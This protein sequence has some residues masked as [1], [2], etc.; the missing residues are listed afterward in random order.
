ME[1]NIIHYENLQLTQMRNLNE[2]GV[3]SNQNEDAKNDSDV[4]VLN[5]YKKKK[6]DKYDEL[7]TTQDNAKHLNHVLPP[8]SQTSSASSFNNDH[9]SST[10]HG[11]SAVNPHSQTLI[12]HA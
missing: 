10:F 12:H 5:N 7:E 3:L 2:L 1:K 4:K 8:A 11:G 6:L 9:G